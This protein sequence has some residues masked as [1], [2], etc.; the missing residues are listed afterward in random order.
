VLSLPWGTHWVS[1]MDGS[2]HAK[3]GVTCRKEYV[4]EAT[5]KADCCGERTVEVDM[6][7]RQWLPGKVESRWKPTDYTPKQQPFRDPGAPVDTLWE[8]GRCHLFDLE[9]AKR[10]KECEKKAKEACKGQETHT[11][12]ELY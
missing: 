5:C 3:D 1:Q 2:A 7:G 4:C 6:K 11:H 8:K 9:E 12:E 10:R